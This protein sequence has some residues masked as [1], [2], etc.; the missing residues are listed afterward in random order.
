MS[1]LGTPKY[2]IAFQP[3][4]ATAPAAEMSSIQVAQL[5]RDLDHSQAVAA[6]RSSL[7]GTAPDPAVEALFFKA[8]EHMLNLDTEFA[9]TDA[10]IQAVVAGGCKDPLVLAFQCLH[11]RVV[12]K[13]DRP[14]LEAAYAALKESKY[15]PQWKMWIAF[16][17]AKHAATHKDEP[18]SIEWAKVAAGHAAEFLTDPAR[19]EATRGMQA[20]RV[21]GFA[22]GKYV[23]ILSIDAFFNTFRDL[24]VQDE[25]LNLYA[26][27]F[28]EKNLAWRMRGTDTADKISRNAWDAFHKHMGLAAAALVKAHALKPDRPEAALE[29]LNITL[30]SNENRGKGPRHWFEE[31]T[32]PRPD[33]MMAY[34]SYMT[35]LLPKWGGSFEAVLD[36]GLE[37]AAKKRY[38]TELP[39]VIDH[40]I[41]T[42]SREIGDMR[43][44]MSRDDVWNA[45]DQS[46]T[47][48]CAHPSHAYEKYDYAVQHV[49]GA[50]AAG[51]PDRAG[52]IA[53]LH[54]VDAGTDPKIY[55]HWQVSPQT[56]AAAVRLFGG[57]QREK[58]LV[59]WSLESQ[60]KWAEAA[61]SYDEIT[62]GDTQPAS[63]MSVSRFSADRAALCTARLN[64]EDNKNVRFSFHEWTE[65]DGTKASIPLML[66]GI[67][68]RFAGGP[69]SRVTMPVAG[70]NLAYIDVP[71]GNRFD[72]NVVIEAP[73][74][75]PDPASS[76]TPRPGIVLGLDGNGEFS[77]RIGMYFNFATRMIRLDNGHS[78]IDTIAFP[79]LKSPARVRVQAWG[80]ELIV[81]V[82]GKVVYSGS[83]EIQDSRGKYHEKG[84]FVG[85]IVYG[86]DLK[87]DQGEVA[88]KDFR[89]I[90]PSVKPKAPPS[91]P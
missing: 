10:A 62:K 24:K 11:I 69:D 33:F 40:V 60:G 8:A 66:R 42:L 46:M 4:V 57:D 65:A 44:I 58:A 19:H 41:Y 54:A 75:S 14:K 17:I 12:K 87:G 6:Y 22:T 79:D 20:L 18:G 27:G 59:A 1:M 83:P 37:A 86:A 52:E 35:S 48:M 36:L 13:E 78:D 16:E 32:R 38:D 9:K 53:K 49:A 63:R 85:L 55:S 21:F 5:T 43:S 84:P 90:R 25:W 77:Q 28:Y 39:K 82:N 29:M 64:F 73:G 70:F 51:H 68:G 3:S 15:S 76:P 26:E 31:A 81:S 88:F 91:K 67:Y 7:N 45:F 2:A 47:G 89:I 72:L 74:P 30:A 23:S 56:F 80:D 34:S 61:A 50:I 71:I